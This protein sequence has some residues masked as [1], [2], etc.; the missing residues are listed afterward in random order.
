VTRNQQ[1]RVYDA[2]L[3]VPSGRVFETVEAV[4]VWVNS[5]RDAPYWRDNYGETVRYV[6]VG[7]AARRASGSVGSY[8]RSACAGRIELAE[9]DELTVVHEVAHVLAE[10]RYDSHAHC[11]WFARVYA[12]LTFVM[13]GSEAWLALQ[14]GY[15]AQGVEYRQ[16]VSS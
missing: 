1:Q 14:R 9:L 13:R 7:R 8:D 6:E 11:P 3:F 15:V 12:E 5:F 10:A 2:E 16:E 4:E